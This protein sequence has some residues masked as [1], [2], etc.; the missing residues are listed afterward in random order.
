MEMIAPR[1]SGTIVTG[2]IAETEGAG[3]AGVASGDFA[4]TVFIYRRHPGTLTGIFVPSKVRAR[5]V[6]A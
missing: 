1:R 4:G 3:K 2:Q 6:S 5:A